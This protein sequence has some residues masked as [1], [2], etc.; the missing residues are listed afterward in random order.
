MLESSSAASQAISGELDEIFSNCDKNQ[1]PYEMP[2]SQ[3]ALYLLYHKPGLKK[4]IFPSK[5]FF[6]PMGQ[7]SPT[8]KYQSLLN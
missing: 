6:R 5:I 3:M 8:Y 4:S 7:K 2:V 1:N